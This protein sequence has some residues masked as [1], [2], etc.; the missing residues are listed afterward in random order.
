MSYQVDGDDLYSDKGSAR[1]QSVNGDGDH[2]GYAASLP[3]SPPPRRNHSPASSPSPNSLGY[4]PSPGNTPASHPN[5][6]AYDVASPSSH[7]SSREGSYDGPSIALPPAAPTVPSD[8]PKFS[9]ISF[10]TFVPTNNG[11]FRGGGGGGFGFGGRGAPPPAPTRNFNDFR[12]G[13]APVINPPHRPPPPSTSHPTSRGPM[14]HPDRMRHVG[15]KPP[16]V[17]APPPPPPPARKKK[18]AS[19]ILPKHDGLR[20]E[21]LA[22]TERIRAKGAE[23]RKRPGAGPGGAGPGGA[24]GAVRK[25]ARPVVRDAKAAGAG[26]GEKKRTGG[27]NLLDLGARVNSSRGGGGLTI[28]RTG[29]D[30]RGSGKGGKRGLPAAPYRQR[31]SEVYSSRMLTKDVLEAEDRV[32]AEK[33]AAEDALFQEQRERE[34]MERKQ[35]SAEMLKVGTVSKLMRDSHHMD[36]FEVNLFGRRGAKEHRAAS[37]QG[38]ESLGL[39]M[40]EPNTKDEKADELWN[41]VIEEF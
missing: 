12:G 4:A 14:V 27:L 10:D 24:G 5:S 9:G 17:S 11:G 25:R 33:Y 22:E 3:S 30:A 39:K 15:V 20:D 34:R 41:V 28:Q 35:R 7:P 36:E 1:S 16:D 18:S 38:D 23:K 26:G 37:G 32:R 40:K 2:D 29:K 6:P 19:S 13:S 21:V 31:G 8:A